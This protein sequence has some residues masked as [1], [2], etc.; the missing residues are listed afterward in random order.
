VAR[1]CVLGSLVA[2][3]AS[4]D[5]NRFHQHQSFSSS[6]QAVHL[7]DSLSGSS[8]IRSRKKDWQLIEEQI[9]VGASICSF[10]MLEIKHGLFFLPNFN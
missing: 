2:V 3:L 6:G 7:L 5:Q 1:W 8:L 10:F 4:L 9:G